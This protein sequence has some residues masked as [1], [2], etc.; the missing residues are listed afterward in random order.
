[1]EKIEE[2]EDQRRRVTAVGGELDDAEGGEAVGA[3][4]AQ[5]AVEIGLAR[6]ELRDGFGDRRILTGPVEPG[7][8]QQLDRAAVEPRM[9]AVAVIFEFMQ[10]VVAFRRHIDQLRELRLDPGGQR[11]GWS[12]RPR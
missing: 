2:E 1:V 6:V 9:H 3:D 8:R 7:A 11:C 4:T 12:G 10:P 5:F